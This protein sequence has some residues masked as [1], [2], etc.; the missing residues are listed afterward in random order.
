MKELPSDS[1][2]SG[3]DTLFLKVE[4]PRRLMTVTSIWTF[5]H[6][7]DS[8]KV[9]EAL[10]QLAMF[11]R[12]SRVPKNESFFRTAKWVAPM[13][14]KPKDNIVLHTLKEPTEKAFQAYCAEQVCRYIC[15]VCVYIFNKYI[16]IGRHS[17]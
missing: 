7:L 3:L 2:L 9:Y 10:N 13:G 15:I 5:K 4:R 17:F 11:P 1:K 14:W 8:N 12:F 6:R 16:Y